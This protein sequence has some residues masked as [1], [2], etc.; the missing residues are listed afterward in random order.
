MSG[1]DKFKLFTSSWFNFGMS[2]IFKNLPMLSRFS[3]LEDYVTFQ[4]KH[5][6]MLMS[7]ACATKPC[8]ILHILKPTNNQL[9]FSIPH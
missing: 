6:F 4:S 8:V 9:S 1:I 7:Y 5:N 2:N 3:T